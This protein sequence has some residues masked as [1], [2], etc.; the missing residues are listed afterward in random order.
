MWEF[1]CDPT[2]K[3]AIGVA[4][5]T[6]FA[7]D[8]LLD[9]HIYV[10]SI[11]PTFGT[12][13][14]VGSPVVTANAPTAVRIS[15]NGQFVYDFSVNRTTAF[16]GPLEGFKMDTTT[17]FLTP[18][19]GSPFATLSIP[20]GGYFNQTGNYMVFH[21]H[22]TL[23]VYNFNVATGIPTENAPLVTGVGDL[24]FAVTDPQ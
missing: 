1:Q 3:F 22:G 16:D 24:P 17:G 10:F 2:G 15:P 6:G 4:G 7:P 14:L 18:L 9:D 11:D 21:E 13:T 20:Y 19:T 23:G 5:E 12:L 8:T